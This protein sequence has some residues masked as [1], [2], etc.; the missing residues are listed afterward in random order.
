MVSL[1][2]LFPSILPVPASFTQWFT[3]PAVGKE[4]YLP[5]VQETQ[6]KWVQSLSQEDPLEE[7]METHSNIFAWGQSLVND[8]WCHLFPLW[9]H[10]RCELCG[11]LDL[12]FVVL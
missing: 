4:S 9:I 6:E 8:T 3:S 12:R 5:A 1:P 7:G 2:V 10:L 11:L